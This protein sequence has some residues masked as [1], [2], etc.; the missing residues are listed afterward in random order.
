MYSGHFIPFAVS[1]LKVSTT[2]NHS[3]T[4]LSFDVRTRQK[5]S[6]YMNL[7]KR[8]EPM[9]CMR[10]AIYMSLIGVD[11]MHNSTMCIAVEW[12]WRCLRIF[13]HV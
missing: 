11:D 12:C 5:I 1:I 2:T 10:Y 6:S 8:T 13:G 9:S 3:Y 4:F 7:A